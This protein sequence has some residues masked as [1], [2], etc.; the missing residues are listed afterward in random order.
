LAVHPVLDPERLSKLTEDSAR[1]L[2]R[3]GQSANTQASYLA[4]MRYWSAWY[5]ARYGQALQLPLAVPVVVQFIVD[6]AERVASA[7]DEGDREER[8]G[9]GG[10]E[11]GAQAGTQEEGGPQRSEGP[12]NEEAEKPRKP[13]RLIFDLPPAVDAALVAAGYK[14]KLGVYSLATLI[15][16]ISVL[17]KAHQ[18]LEVANPC[19]HPQVRELLKNVRTG[20][21]KRGV[22]PNKLAARTKDPFQAILATCDESLRGK[23]D[24]AL[25]LFAW[26]SGGRRRSEV[27]SAT[28]DNLKKVG[29][30]GYLYTLGH[31]KTNQEGKEIPGNDKPVAGMAAEALEAWLAASGVVEGLVFRRILKGG[32]V[33]EDGLDPKAVRM[34]VQERSRLAGLDGEFSAHSLRSGFV[35]EAGRRKMPAADAM[36]MTGHRNYVSFMGY[37]R[38]DDPLESKASRMLDEDSGVNSIDRAR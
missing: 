20:Y 3:Q 19:H 10:Q 25:L 17:S 23:R 30:R 21:A 8:G 13:S 7:K 16:R 36:A 29:N 37:Y 33:L 31:S 14:G 35:T 24:R 15:H 11:K 38:A 32:K 2:I 6:H 5:G 22:N 12:T 28:M 18:N 4:A 27:T 1:E 26:A 9:E 34:I